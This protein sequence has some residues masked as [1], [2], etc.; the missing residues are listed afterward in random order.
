ME[1]VFS[2]GWIGAMKQ[3]GR[4]RQVNAGNGG[5]WNSRK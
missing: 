4:Q 2:S 3:E 1:V 5:D